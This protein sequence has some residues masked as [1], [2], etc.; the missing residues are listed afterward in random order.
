MDAAGLKQGVFGSLHKNSPPQIFL[1]FTAC[2]MQMGENP[3]GEEILFLA[4]KMN[5]EK[6]YKDC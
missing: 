1:H 2:P 6:S 5:R 4:Y 3:V